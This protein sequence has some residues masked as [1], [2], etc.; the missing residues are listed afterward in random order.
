MG[1]DALK[2]FRDRFSIAITDEEIKDAPFYKPDKDSEEIK[3]LKARRE[4]LG[5]YFFSKRKSPPKLEIPDIDT[6]SYT[7]LTL[8]TILLV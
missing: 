2:H 4:E 7:H 3:Y 8:P 1:E 5:G 6:V